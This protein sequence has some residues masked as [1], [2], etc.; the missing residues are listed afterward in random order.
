MNHLSTFFLFTICIAFYKKASQNVH[1]VNF[2]ND[3]YNTVGFPMKLST[4]S[5][6][7]HDVYIEGDND[8]YHEGLTSPIISLPHLWIWITTELKTEEVCNLDKCFSR[9]FVLKFQFKNKRECSITPVSC[10]P[11]LVRTPLFWLQHVAWTRY[12]SWGES[13]ILLYTYSKNINHINY[14]SNNLDLLI[15]NLGQTKM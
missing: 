7:V 10:P 3:A 2:H 13:L 4:L 1:H 15:L 9:Y 8:S 14:Y 11:S 6:G 5:S 12:L